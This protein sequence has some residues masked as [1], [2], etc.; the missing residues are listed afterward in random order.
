[1]K[2]MKH[3]RDL[4]HTPVITVA[5]NDTLR[6]AVHLMEHHH[7]RH[8]P[9]TD[10]GQLVGILTNGDIREHVVYMGDRY[11]SGDSFNEVLETPIEGVMTTDVKVLHPEHTVDDALSLFLG[12]KF[13]G[14]PVVD[15]GGRLVGMLTYIDLLAEFRRTLQ[16]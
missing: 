16:A 3:I 5:P 4:M 11:E 14:A 2:R 8:L 1:M 7:I 9:V 12:E 15:A 10:N 13:G 6:H